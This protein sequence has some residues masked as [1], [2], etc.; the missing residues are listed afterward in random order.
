MNAMI[1]KAISDR[2]LLGFTYKGT[3]RWVEPHTY[4]VQLNGNEAL[5]ASQVTGGSG[6]GFRLF[7]IA[8]MA[9]LS[10]GETFIG[11]RNGYRQGDRRFQAIYAEL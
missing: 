3:Q 9:R 8:E 5:S 7:V 4:G 2:T 1:C 11:P 10:I 6:D